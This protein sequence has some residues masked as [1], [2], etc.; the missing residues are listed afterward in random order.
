MMDFVSKLLYNLGL[1]AVLGIILY[2][3]FPEIMGGVF[4]AS[5]LIYGGP[6]IILMLVVYALPNRRRRH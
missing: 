6:L 4:Q 5:L 1:L 3:A 2:V